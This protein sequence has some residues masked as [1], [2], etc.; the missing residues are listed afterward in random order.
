MDLNI[1][2]LLKTGFRLTAISSFFVCQL[3][4]AEPQGGVVVAGSANIS[5]QNS[6]TI[7]NQASQSAVINWASF[8]TA[9]SESVL[10]HQPSSSSIALNK[11]T[12][13]LPT[14]FNGSLSANGQVWIINPAGVLFGSSANINVAGLVATTHN[15][16]NNNFMAGN[17]IFDAPTN[18]SASI[19]NNG[20]ITVADSGIVALVGPNVINNGIIIANL[21]K[22]QLSTGGAFVLDLNGDGLINFGSNSPIANGSVANNNLIKATGGKVYMTANAAAGILDNVVS[23]N[24]TIEATTATTGK[25]GEIILNGG[26]SGVTHIS[27]TLRAPKGHIETSGHVLIIDPSTVI[28]A[29]GGR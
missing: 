21:G 16:N 24:G 10:F 26:S 15:I 6:Q 28:D 7:I 4:F 11:I 1:T 23:M 14:N 29:S 2:N 13:G 22:V 20:N 3:A 5:Q 12:S 9:A 17:Y 19:I 18:L 25:N 8:D 27:G